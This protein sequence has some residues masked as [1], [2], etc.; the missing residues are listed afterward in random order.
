MHWVDEIAYRKIKLILADAF[1][2]D[3]SHELDHLD[4]GKLNLESCLALY[5]DILTKILDQHAP[6]KKK[7]VPNQKRVP[8]LTEAIREEIRK[9]RKM[10]RIW[11]HDRENL[12]RYRDFCSQ[13]RLV[14][15]LLF[16]AEKEFYRSNLHKHH[17]Y[18]KQVFKLCD[19]L[20]GQKKNNYSPPDL[21]TKNWLIHLTG[22]S[23]L[24][25]PT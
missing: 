6:I 25:Y 23:S 1:A 11:R 5:N 9:C 24:R 18:I 7:S 14:S 10:E 20:L 15:N 2:S 3:I 8:W 13:C 19:C 17:G 12:D 16:V 22:F 4:V 21:T